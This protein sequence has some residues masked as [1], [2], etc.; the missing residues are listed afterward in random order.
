MFSSVKKR[1]GDFEKFRKEKLQ[2]S[3]ASALKDAQHSDESAQ[4][5]RHVLKSLEKHPH[6]A[7][8]TAYLKSLVEETLLDMHLAHAAK[9]YALFDTKQEGDTFTHF[10]S[11]HKAD[12][13]ANGLTVL[14]KR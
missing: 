7:P 3:I 12:I 11:T 2:K 5:L 4:V 8:T 14:Q 1:S 9:E 10:F 6:I 13:H